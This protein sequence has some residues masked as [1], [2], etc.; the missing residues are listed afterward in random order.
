VRV[1]ELAAHGLP[2][3]DELGDQLL[4]GY[5]RDRRRAERARRA[6]RGRARR[7]RGGGLSLLFAALLLLAAAAA[8][9]AAT[10]YV[11]HASPIAPFAAQDVPAEQRVAPG[12]SHVL[13]LRA[14]D[15][16]GAPAWTLRLARS[17]T[18]L[19]CGTVGQVVGGEF[20][21]VGLDH[22]FRAVPEIN[23]DACGQSSRDGVALLGTRVFDATRYG[24]VRTVI[25]GVAGSDLAQVL[26]GLRGRAPRPV[27]HDGDGAF[28][29]AATGYPEDLQPVV[30]LRWSDGHTR[31]VALVA[32]PSVVAD[33]LGGR[34]WRAELFSG[35]RHLRTVTE[36]NGR[37]VKVPVYSCV[38]FFT[39]RWQK[40]GVAR[41]PA[42][43]G[44]AHSYPA[45][46]RSLFFTT[47]R[48]SGGRRI[49][50]GT[51][52][53][54][55][56]NRHAPRTALWGAIGR[57]Q[58]REIVITA[59]GIRRTLRPTFNGL[60]L[61]VLPP[62]V[63]PARVRVELRL[64]GGAVRRLGPSFGLVDPKVAF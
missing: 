16:A 5:R 42:A 37:H 28:L 1:P 55:A 60:L 53:G 43:C 59:P 29:V 22:R 11:L 31:R 20:G 57:A 30:V 41:S 50:D 34:A 2:I 54:G 6:P 62:S 21:L 33:P 58:A 48:L 18:G 61:V 46:D 39:A 45:P 49:E 52:I 64:A 3:L 19:V 24:D 8:A 44:F 38:S 23:A 13:A 7:R 17:D 4:A 14:K 26:V 32:S 35:G 10:Y 56:W 40:S 47:R 15:P 12:T 9:G 63:D 51:R 25:N 36:P 27:A